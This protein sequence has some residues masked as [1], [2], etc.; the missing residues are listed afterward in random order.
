[1]ASVRVRA[2]DA[3]SASLRALDHLNRAG[4][5]EFD[6]VTLALTNLD[7]VLFP[8]RAK[9][10]PLTKRDLI[11][12]YAAR[13]PVML[14]YLAGRAVNMHRYPNGVEKPGFWHKEVPSHSPDWITR[15]HYD[16]AYPDETQ[17]Y[18]VADSVPTLAWLANYGAIELNPWTSSVRSAH[19][20]TWALIDVDPGPNT[21][22]GDLVLLAGLYRTALE[23]LGVVGGPKV[24]GKRGI[25]V[26]VPI[27]PGY[28][29]E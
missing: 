14:P 18:F 10:R 21:S 22:W 4:E 5:W 15:W 13:A 1:M 7:K 19:E 11:R 28:T 17:W 25:Q 9:E 27:A 26:W 23:H 20:P 8:P 3:S 29:F 2:A 24:T 6:G 12:H 16:D